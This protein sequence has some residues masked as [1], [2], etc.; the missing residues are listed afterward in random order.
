MPLPR[1]KIVLYNADAKKL[2]AA[3][4]DTEAA[5]F[6]ERGKEL[7]RPADW[8]RGVA[9]A[10]TVKG[11]VQKTPYTVCEVRLSEKTDADTIWQT[12]KQLASDY[13][14]QGISGRILYHQCSHDDPVVTSC[15]AEVVEF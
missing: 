9:L 5:A 2:E 4:D 6:A 8:V 12:I 13:A 10:K 11:E 3:Q 7:D 14:A 1:I 15:V